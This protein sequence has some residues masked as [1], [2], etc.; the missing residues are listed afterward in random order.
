MFKDDPGHK[1]KDVFLNTIP[2][3]VP[4]FDGIKAISPS[5]SAWLTSN[6]PGLCSVLM[7]ISVVEVR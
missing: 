6:F 3:L 7:L 2:I 4:I 5:M 1:L